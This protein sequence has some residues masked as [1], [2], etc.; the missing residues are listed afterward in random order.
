L[1]TRHK[2]DDI[3]IMRGWAMVLAGGP[4]EMAAIDKPHRGP[5]SKYPDMKSWDGTD[6]LQ[7][8]AAELAAAG[9]DTLDEQAKALGIHRSTAWTIV[10]CKHKL[11]RLNIKTR[12]KM[13]NNPHLP[14]G[15][16]AILQDN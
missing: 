1:A 13:L 4:N 12:Q 16:R 14:P 10:T 2:A 3:T 6:L 15:V 11:G 9:Y 8:L 7:R 5:R